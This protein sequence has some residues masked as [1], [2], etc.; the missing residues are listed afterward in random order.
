[1]TMH[2]LWAWIGKRH[3][4]TLNYHDDTGRF[5]FEYAPD[6]ISQ[7]GAYPVSP[8]LPFQRPEDLTDELHSVDTRRFFENLLPEG[9]ALED[10]ATAHAVSKSNLFGL[11]QMKTTP[12]L[13]EKWRRGRDSNPGRGMPLNGFQD[14]RIRPLCHLSDLPAK[15]SVIYFFLQ[16]KI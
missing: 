13:K 5:S 9:K 16:L 1:M 4:G 7:T 8:A 15:S 10:A 14:R 12:R 6:W 2:S 11:L 3:I